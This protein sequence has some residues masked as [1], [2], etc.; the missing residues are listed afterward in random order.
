M[1]S[2]K[3]FGHE[4]ITSSH[5]NTFE[6][7]K[8]KDIGKLAHCIIGIKADFSVKD[9]KKIV[10]N[11]D[12]L[13]I[14]IKVDDLKEEINCISNKDFSDSEEIVIRKSDFLSKRTLGIRCDKASSDLKKEFK[15]KLKNPNQEIKIKIV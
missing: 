15:E 14:I 3:C 5:K 10:R 13:K 8:H 11:K 12:K 4:N 7:T 2:F 6:F 1:Y 9:I